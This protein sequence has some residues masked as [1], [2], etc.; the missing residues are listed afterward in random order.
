MADSTRKTPTPLR[1]VVRDAN[2]LAEKRAALETGRREDKREWAL[3]R[4]FYKGNQ[5]SWWNSNQL[6]V[7][8]LPPV[9]ETG[10]NRHRVRLVSNQIMPGVQNIISQL[11]KTRPI[12]HATPNSSAERDAKAAELA[13]G[14]Y[15][16]W[17]HEFNLKSKLQRALLHAQLSEGFWKISWDPYAGKQMTFLLD[18]NTGQPMT[19]MELADAFKDKLEDMA[20]QQQQD[21]AEILQQIQKTVM[22]GDIRVEVMSGEQV[23][24]DPTVSDFRQAAY[25]ICRHSMDPEEVRARW[26]VQVEP[27]SA[28]A[29]YAFPTG[30]ASP[31]KMTRDVYIGYFKPTSYLPKGRYVAWIEGPNKIL[32][33]SD[34]PY[35]FTEL[36]LVKFPGTLNPDKAADSPR[37]SQ[38]RGLNKELNRTISQIVMH[39]NLTLKPQMVAPVGSLRERITDEPGAVFEYQPI[40]GLSPEWR[41]M[42]NL[43]SYVFEHVADIQRRID[44]IFNK[45]PSERNQLPPRVDAG[46]TVELLQEAVADQLSPE[47]QRIE[48]SLVDA[49]MLMLLLAQKYY[50]EPRLMKLRGTGGSTQVKKFINTDL[51]GG[52]GLH[53]E[54]GSGLPSTRAGRMAQVKELVQMQAISPQDALPYLGLSNLKGMADKMAGDEDQAYREIEKL[55]NGDPINV[56]AAQK[57]VQ[58]VQSGQPNP[59]TQEPFQ[60][61]EEAQAFITQAMLSPLPYENTAVHLNVMQKFMVG[62]GFEKYPPE[63]QDRFLQHFMLTQ[64]VMQQAAAAGGPSKPI[65]TTLSLKGTVGPT[66]AAAILNKSG[67]PQVTPEV[68]HEAPLET[69]VYDSMDKPD[70]DEAGNDPMSQMDQVMAAQQMQIDAAKGAHEVALAQYRTDNT[71]RSNATAEAAAHQKMTHAEEAHQAALQRADQLHAQQ[72]QLNQDRAAQPAQAGEGQ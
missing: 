31:T 42:P 70:M 60:S 45:I 32:A 56:S 49:G 69:S 6:Q 30:K 4:E 28:P 55:I 5:W 40:A 72:M 65:A 35:P 1:D 20:K 21:P 10:G 9:V 22:L 64:Q 71:A 34:W 16:Y 3:N 33:Q 53:A 41:P 46:Y 8:S 15:D 17:W 13:E 19:D 2:L 44:T 27:D 58:Y 48:E 61:M 23:L 59:A 43:P 24:V 18:P 67:I 51:V 7:E 68:M 52:F 37:V 14:L 66:A 62:Q 50:I 25:A 29:D 11:T 26:G 38:A 36:P 39:K 54:A 63:V 57:A 12:I 47:I